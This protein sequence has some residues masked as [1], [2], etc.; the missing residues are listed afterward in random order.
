MNNSEEELAGHPL[1]CVLVKVRQIG[2]YGRNVI[3]FGHHQFSREEL[4][5]RHDHWLDLVQVEEALSTAEYLPDEF[6]GACTDGREEYLT[7]RHYLNNYVIR[8]RRILP[9]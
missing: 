1:G 9:L 2:A 3:N 7:C 8:L 4:N 6:D 5:A